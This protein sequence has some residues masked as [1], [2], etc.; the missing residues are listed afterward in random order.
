MKQFVSGNLLFKKRKEIFMKRATIL[1]GIVVSKSELFTGDCIFIDGNTYFI[2]CVFNN[3]Y[4]EFVVISNNQNA[5][6]YKYTV[7][8]NARFS[9]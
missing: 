1:N 6:T 4:G 7:N 5:K 9:N 2:D 3:N 8:S